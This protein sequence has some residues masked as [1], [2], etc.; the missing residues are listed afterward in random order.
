MFRNLHHRFSA[1][2]DFACLMVLAVLP[3]SA[4][5][6]TR[7]P[8]LARARQIAE[9]SCVSCHG[10]NGN[11]ISETTPKIAG[12]HT[13][14]LY[15]QLRDFVGNSEKPAARENVLMVSS[16]AILSDADLYSLASFYSTQ[17]LLPEKAKNLKTIEQGQRLWRAGN[18]ERGIPACAGCHGP[19]GQG[20]PPLYPRLQGQ[21]ATYLAK[22]L[23]AYQAGTIH[24]DPSGMMRTIA[25][26]MNQ[27]E[28]NAVADYAA[29][30]R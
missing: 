12:Q 29:G 17:T 8:D 4:A 18:L 15:K 1:R 10:R 16:L 26:R 20:M 23:N 9:T 19:A 13:G 24:N 14:Y 11:S 6:Q 27:A 22:M 25:Q 2:L 21:F 7:Q 28:I 30:L 3:L 5:C